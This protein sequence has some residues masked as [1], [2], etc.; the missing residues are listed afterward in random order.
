MSAQKDVFTVTERR[1]LMVATW[2]AGI[3]FVSALHVTFGD[4]T[5]LAGLGF[6]LGWAMRGW[7]R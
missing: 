4:F 5:G 7:F 6:G 1:L 2:F 3:V